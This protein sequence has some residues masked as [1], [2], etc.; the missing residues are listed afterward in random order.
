MGV[1]DG[2]RDREAVEIDAD[3]GDVGNNEGR[4]P[5]SG[6]FV[7]PFIDMCNHT[8][9]DPAAFWRPAYSEKKKKEIEGMNLKT[10]SQHEEAPSG[11][12]TGKEQTRRRGTRRQKRFRTRR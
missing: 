12:R 4:M 8:H 1:G 3:I 9:V 6:A 11:T 10:T 7:A 5:P 2:K